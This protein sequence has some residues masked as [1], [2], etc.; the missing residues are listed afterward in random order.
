MEWTAQIDAYCE[1]IGPSLWAEPINAVTNLAFLIAAVFMWTRLKGHNLPLAR[2]MAAALALVG[3]AS[4][5]WHTFALGWTGAADSL[6]ILVFILIYLFASNRDFWGLSTP[7]AALGTLAFFP[8]AIATGW[9]IARVPFFEVSGLYWSVALLIGGTAFA[10]RHRAPDTARNLGIGAGILCVSI[11]LRSLDEALCPSL[12][13]GTHFLWHVL[14]G[15]MLG[16]M[17]ETYRRHMI[18]VT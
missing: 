17:I 12:P 9:V 4:G 6:S 2:A 7:M 10:L 16:W 15:I 18:R 3:I 5:A 14:N 11:T 8:F 13:V 1:R